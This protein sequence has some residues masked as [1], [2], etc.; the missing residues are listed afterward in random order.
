MDI[1]MPQLT[2]FEAAKIIKNLKPQ[3]PIIAQ[4]AYALENEG[5][6]YGGIF[7][8]YITKPIY[9][10]KFSEIVTRYFKKYL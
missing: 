1:K 6:Q 10:I 8:D 2:R 9:E 4:S 7:D 3:L 5:A